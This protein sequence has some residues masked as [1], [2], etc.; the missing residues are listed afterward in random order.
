MISGAIHYGWVGVDLDGTLAHYDGWRGHD[1]IGPP[2]QK[3]LERVL[4]WLEEGRT[5]KIFTARVSDRSCEIGSVNVADVTVIIHAWCIKHG[6]PAL[7]VTCEKDMGMV[8]LWDDRAV[9]VHH[10]TGER[11]CRGE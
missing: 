1:H 5:V 9:R 11:C 6:L 7:E 8:E 3:M 10:N 4:D 2:I